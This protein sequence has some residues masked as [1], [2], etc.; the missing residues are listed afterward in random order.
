MIKTVFKRNYY[1]KMPCYTK[2]AWYRFPNGEVAEYLGYDITEQVMKFKNISTGIE[3]S[4][5]IDN[6][7]NED[8]TIEFE[9]ACSKSTA[10]LFK[11]SNKSSDKHQSSNKHQH[12]FKDVSKL[13][14]IDVYSVLSLFEVTDPCIQH[15]VK[16]LLCTGKRGYKDFDKDVQDAIDSLARCQELYKELN[17]TKE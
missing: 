16:K 9:L 2:G 13:D 12:Y 10:E 15:A 8:G 7:Y 4:E 17:Q 5:D 6:A 1:S 11:P 14:K 3:F